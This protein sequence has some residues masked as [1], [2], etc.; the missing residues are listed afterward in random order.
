MFVQER[1]AS[2]TKHFPGVCAVLLL[3]ENYCGTMGYTLW[4]I[5]KSKV[6]LSHDVPFDEFCETQKSSPFLA[7]DD[8]GQESLIYWMGS[9]TDEE[10]H[11]NLME[12]QQKSDEHL[13]R[14]K[15]PIPIH[16]PQPQRSQRMQRLPDRY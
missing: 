2:R 12:D 4:I 3:I 16:E 8:K 9:K 14:E 6:V 11:A 10:T 13:D 5:E 1:K 7:H 15:E